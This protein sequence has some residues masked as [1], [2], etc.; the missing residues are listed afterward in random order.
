MIEVIGMDEM[1]MVSSELKNA[2]WGIEM[3]LKR[4][5]VERAMEFLKWAQEEAD[6]LAV[7]EA[8]CLSKLL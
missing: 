3:A 1:K 8:K 5:D 6:E 4:G 7:F 2:L